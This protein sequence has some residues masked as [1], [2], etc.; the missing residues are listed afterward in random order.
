[1]ASVIQVNLLAG[2]NETASATAHLPSADSLLILMCGHRV[3]CSLA[4]PA[5]IVDFRMNTVWSVPN[6]QKHPDSQLS[7]PKLLG[8]GAVMQLTNFRVSDQ[9]RSAAGIVY[10]FEYQLAVGISRIGENWVS[11]PTFSTIWIW[12]YTFSSYC[13]ESVFFK[14]SCSLHLIR[15]STSD[16]LWWPVYDVS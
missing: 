7:A 14:A 11:E 8:L 12:S 6:Y 9:G 13:V 3:A 10:D 5:S 4:N 1:M 15:F 16:R 2:W